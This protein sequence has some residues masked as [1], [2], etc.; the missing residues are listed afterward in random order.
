MNNNNIKKAYFR[1]FKDTKNGGRVAL[2]MKPVMVSPN[3]ENGDN[4][5]FPFSPLSRMELTLIDTRGNLEKKVYANL[6]VKAD[7]NEIAHLLSAYE[8]AKIIQAQSIAQGITK[9]K[10]PE[11][12]CHRFPS[13]EFGGETPAEVLL[14][15]PTKINALLRQKDYYMNNINNYPNNELL[16]NSIINAIDLFN[17]GTLKED[18]SDKCYNMLNYSF[19]D[20]YRYNDGQNSSKL[21][22]PKNIRSAITI[23]CYPEKAYAWTITIKNKNLLDENAGDVKVSFIMNDAEMSSF[24]ESIKIPYQTQVLDYKNSKIV[25]AIK[26]IFD[27]LFNK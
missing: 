19:K 4:M 20:I 9:I 25:Y 8:T 5:Y 18:V 21:G 17:E 7:K 15:D 22:R 1:L 27:R 26:M 6:S 23:N 16:V 14:R 24:I 3:R 13:G 11:A 10:K 2:Y 12:Y